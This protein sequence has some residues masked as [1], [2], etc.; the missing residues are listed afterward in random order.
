MPRRPPGHGLPL[1]GEGEAERRGRPACFCILPIELRADLP[2]ARIARLGNDSE[3][4]R[5]IDVSGRILKLC[6]VEDVEKF[7]TEIEGEILL[8]LC[9]LCYSEI[10]VIEARAVEASPVGGA[11]SS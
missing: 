2:D 11:K 10:G 9:S 8:N 7:E 4:A 5:I 1:S 6:V 3:A